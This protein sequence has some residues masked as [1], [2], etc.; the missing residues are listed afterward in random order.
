MTLSLLLL[1]D[2]QSVAHMDEEPEKDVLEKM[3]ESH[4]SQHAGWRSS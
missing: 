4:P 2:Q 1:Q 3:A